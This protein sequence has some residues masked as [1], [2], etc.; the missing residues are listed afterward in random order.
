MSVDRASDVIR[1]A[2]YILIVDTDAERI[3]AAVRGC[4]EALAVPTV[5]ARNVDDAIRILLQFGSPAV[6]M[7]SLAVPDQD[8]LSVI[9]SLRRV[10]PDAPVIAW[11]ADRDVRE[12][13]AN[14]LAGTRAKV[15]SRAWSA[16]VCRRCVDALLQ[17]DATSNG[18]TLAAMA[19]VGE[20]WLHLAETA[21]QRLGVIG[22]AAYTKVLGA[23][24]YRLSVSWMPDAPMLDFPVILPSA[25]KEVIASGVAR[26]W[27]DLI[28]EAGRRASSAAAQMA[29]RSLAIVPIF[30]DGQTVGALCV[31]NSEP[32]AFRPDTL[33]ALSAVAGRTTSRRSGPAMAIDRD[34]AGEIIKTELARARRDQLPLAVVLF[35]VTAAED[36]LPAIGEMLVAAVRGDDLVV[37]WTSSEVL[38]ML[39]GVHRSIARRVA[40]RIR[41]VV[42]TR[43][44]NRI[45]V[46]D[47]VTEL[48]ADDSVEDAIARAAGRL[49]NRKTIQATFDQSA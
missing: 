9:E 29:L 44:A 43:V 38:L 32:H 7:V 16:A 31:F 47:A 24:E 6:L 41:G 13:A 12:Y 23:A 37:R 3:D 14:L 20:N 2:S 48:R 30:R 28:N 40:E 25:L 11:A 27:T 19:A 8:G 36:D 35:A 22:A 45:A 4:G 10:D 5:V 26:M 42:Q 17:R 33:E 15:L 1:P 21:R 18:S 49:Q 34:A 39:A 46:L